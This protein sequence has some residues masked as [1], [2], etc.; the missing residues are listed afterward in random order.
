MKYFIYPILISLIGLDLQAQDV[1]EPLSDK[2]VTIELLLVEYIHRDGFNWGINILNAQ[3]GKFGESSFSPG[4]ESGILSL[5]YD[6]TV[7][8]NE[9]FKLNLQSL[10][11][12]NEASIFTK[13]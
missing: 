3:K 13:P 12:N 9:K 7:K 6:I 8:L 10:V 2:Q 5:D 1:I 11:E 4:N